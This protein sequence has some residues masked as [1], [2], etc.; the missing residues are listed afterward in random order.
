MSQTF[1]QLLVAVGECKSAPCVD[2][3][4][5]TIEAIPE[6][7]ERHYALGY[8]YYLHPGRMASPAI[9]GLVDQHLDQ[10]LLLGGFEFHAALYR[11][12]NAYDFADYTVAT[13]FF[14]RARVVAPKSYIGLKAIEMLAATALSSEHSPRSRTGRGS[15]PTKVEDPIY[16]V[17]DVW[18]RVLVKAL[19]NHAAALPEA[20]RGRV[21]ED[22]ARID[23]RG[24]LRRWLV[25]ALDGVRSVDDGTD[26][27][28]P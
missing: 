27:A 16:A 13:E 22:L 11:G 20:V 15:S 3:I 1:V 14:E 28:D 23:T 18:P 24:E 21:R 4:L 26:K 5:A 10:A 25:D 6:D 19:V 17:E 9:R 12:H 7:A 8:C 2:S